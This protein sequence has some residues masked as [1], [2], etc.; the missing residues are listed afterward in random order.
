MKGLLLAGLALVALG[1]CGNGTGA[2]GE[3][4]ARALDLP[5]DVGAI[6]GDPRILGVELDDIGRPG[7]GCGI[8]DPVRVY[9]VGG[10]LLSP[11]PRMNCEAASA[12][13]QWSDTD[14]ARAAK[15][16]GLR[17][18]RLNVASGYA[19]RRRNNASRGRLSEHAKG[20]AIDISAVTFTNG[21]TATVL[22]DWHRGRYS[23]VMQGLHGS[24]CGS[25][26]VV[27]GPRADRHHR[28]HFHFDISNRN[29]P[30]CR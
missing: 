4:L 10:V 16:A 30:Y 22:G 5:A 29:R 3:R 8:D 28:D 19:C 13:R 24:A 18:A 17:I 12:L 2:E 6:C 23:K 1:S 27:L 21:E 14:G 9:A 25:F 26:G 15:D 20:N 7:Q 11:R